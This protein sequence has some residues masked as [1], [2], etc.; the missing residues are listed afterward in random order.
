MSIFYEKKYPKKLFLDYKPAQL[1]QTTG[2]DWRI[3]YYYRIPGKNSFKRFRKSV[4][5]VKNKRERKRLALRLC[6]NINHELRQGWSPFMDGDSKGNF[7]PFTQVLN[8]FIQ[9]AERK[10][11]DGLIRPDTLRSYKSFVTV[12]AKYQKRSDNLNM[13]A[14]EF[15][16]DF[17]IK[18]LDYI[19]FELKRTAR[20]S[21][22]HLNFLSQIGI[23]MTD[24]NIITSNPAEKIQK[25]KVSKK[26]RQTL[27]NDIR[28]RIFEYL[29]ETSPSYL[30]LSM[31]TYFC[32]I[33]RTELTKLKVQNV[34]LRERTIF[35]PGEISKNGTN[36]TVTIPKKLL[37]LLINH[38]KKAN[39]SDYLFSQN[40]FK[41][42]KKKLAP[43]KISDEWAKMRKV[44]NLSNVY[45][46]YSLK[47]T[48][49]TN[50]LL[51]GVAAKKV[52]DQ[53]RHHDIRITEK[54]I[55]R[56]EE[57]DQE[58]TEIDFNF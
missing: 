45:Q 53:A 40:D 3:V 10:L 12:I 49:I 4:P 56:T 23:F 16:R 36:G 14:V 8:Q 17:I 2:S 38:L 13:A 6:E 50:L 29:A 18:Y 24:R 1:K 58:L 20:T 55:S 34:N 46:F 43:K 9:Q 19:Y 15:T 5:P 48:G 27:P 47:D 25:R 52:R 11:K 7:K 57:A 33:R 51:L 26:K 21:N 54:Y 30:T 22:N 41:P 32:F 42:G 28:K 39:N 31:T 35:I 44:L 37:F